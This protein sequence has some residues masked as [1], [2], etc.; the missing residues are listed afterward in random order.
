MARRAWLYCVLLA[1]GACPDVFAASDSKTD[2]APTS[3]LPA[4]PDPFAQP[5]APA[6][7]ATR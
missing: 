4:A 1:A 5:D 3:P 7:L 2:S 6:Q